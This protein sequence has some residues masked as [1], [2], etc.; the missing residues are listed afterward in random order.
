MNQ[1]QSDDG[2]VIARSRLIVLFVILAGGLIPLTVYW[3]VFGML[4]SVTPTL[5]KGLLGTETSQAILIDIRKST[6]FALAHIDGA[7]NWPLEEILGLDS[8]RQIPKQFQERTLLLICDGGFRSSIAVRHLMQLGI[9][10]VKNVRGG[11][12]EWIASVNSPQGGAFERFSSESGTKSQFPF[13][14]SPLLEQL[15][16]VISGFAIKPTYTLLSLII[17]IVLWRSKS[18]DLVSLR[19]SMICFFIGENFCAANY[20]FFTDKSYLF[21]FLHSYGMLL[22]FG[23]VTYAVVEGIDS[24][25]LMLSDP[26]KRCSAMGLCVKCIKYEDVS[27]GLRRTFLIIIPAMAIVAL[28]P[29]FA[30]RHNVSYNTTIFGTFYNYSRRLIY[31][32]FEMQYC[33][34]S[35]ILMFVISLGIL[36]FKKGNPLP[37]AKI[38]F[39]AGAGPLGFGMFRS[40][41]TALYSHNLVWFAFWEEATELMFIV[42][43]CF[44]LWLFRKSLFRMVPDSA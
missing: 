20:Y 28:M 31:Q 9:K 40:V 36:I 18:A 10:D 21:E 29:L 27:C 25:I 39:A 5:A 22:A 16:A 6:D 12:Q 24:R 19:W 13:R 8:D 11:I 1:T 42:G 17:A 14:Q 23:F 3:F 32:H 43:V 38:F 35:A 7:F 26:D 37:M 4:P 33:P 2:P 44:I 34:L 41:L 30:D 15:A